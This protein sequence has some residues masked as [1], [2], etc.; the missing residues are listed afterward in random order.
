MAEE[1]KSIVKQYEI[2]TCSGKRLFV[3]GTDAVSDF[4]CN[5]FT[6]YDEKG[7]VAAQFRLDNI[8]GW[9]INK[10]GL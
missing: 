5:D 2:Y 8:E 1:K 6:I 9:M 3:T 4:L 7:Q 10:G